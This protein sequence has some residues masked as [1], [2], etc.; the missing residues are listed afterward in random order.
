VEFN[1]GLA[2]NGQYY[3]SEFYGGTQS[4]FGATA[5]TTTAGQAVTGIN[6]TLLPAGT[7]ALGLPK[8]SGA[9]LSGLHNNKVALNQEAALITQRS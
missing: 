8:E 2:L 3:A 4:E 1:G 7:T 5:I 6:G 9:A